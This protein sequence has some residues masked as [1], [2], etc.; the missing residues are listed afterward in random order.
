MSDNASC[1]QTTESK[2]GKKLRHELPQKDKKGNSHSQHLHL[3]GPNSV[4]WAVGHTSPTYCCY[5]PSI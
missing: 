2:Y 1:H 4:L 5:L 3:H